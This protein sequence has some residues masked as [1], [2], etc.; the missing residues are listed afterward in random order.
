[1]KL[2][3]NNVA[4]SNENFTAEVSMFCSETFVMFHTQQTYSA[5]RLSIS[6]QNQNFT[7]LLKYI[8]L[9]KIK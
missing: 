9:D 5:T 3:Q 7:K 4:M 2:Q 8:K 6:C 1:M